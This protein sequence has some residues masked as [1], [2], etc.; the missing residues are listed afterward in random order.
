M[1]LKKKIP[2]RRQVKIFLY[3]FQFDRGIHFR[4]KATDQAPCD[5]KAGCRKSTD[6]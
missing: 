2:A 3:L 5:V 1:P 4:S 6:F